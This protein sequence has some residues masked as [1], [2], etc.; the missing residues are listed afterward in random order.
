ML[1]RHFLFSVGIFKSKKASVRSIVIGN[2]KI[3]GTGKT[4]FAIWLIE[5]FDASKTGFVSRGY[6]RKTK[7][8]QLITSNSNISEIGDEPSVVRNHFNAL[9]GAVSENRLSGIYLLRQAFPQI[10]Q[11]VLDDAFQH[12]KLNP[13]F[14]IL[15]TTY[16]DLFVND[17]LFP[18]GGLRD[19]KKRAYA[20][21]AIIVTKCPDSLSLEEQQNIKEQLQLSA[22]QI[23]AFTGIEYEEPIAAFD[24]IKPWS[25]NLRSVCFAGLANPIPFFMEGRNRSLATIEMA[26][27]DHHEYTVQDVTRIRQEWINFGQENTVLLTTEK[28]VVKCKN[29]KEF[30]DL[31][32]YFLRMKIK[33]I[34]GEFALLNA[35][36]EVKK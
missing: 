14:S 26:L 5:Q 23:L 28:D 15:L 30:E 33:F 12:R 10:Q 31:P 8:F 2:L 3:G 9:L 29:I 36:K 34:A 21:N 20:A 11:V 32:L 13:D 17:E 16:N 6:G 22:Q 4:P 25:R 18:V 1:F 24:G 27:N 7:G 19:L 35:L